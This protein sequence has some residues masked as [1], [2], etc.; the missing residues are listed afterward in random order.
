MKKYFFY[1]INLIRFILNIPLII[2][3]KIGN[4]YA[5]ILKLIDYRN[6]SNFWQEILN[7]SIYEFKSNKIRIS[8]NPS[9]FIQFYTPSKIA[10]YRSKTFF[11]KEPE[12]IDWLNRCGDEKKYFF[13]IGS[14]MGIYSIYYAK[15]F[16][17]QVFSFE[18][19]YKN[20]EI[21]TKNIMLNSL[22]NNIKIISNPLSDD[23][24]FSSFIQNDF[25]AG[26]AKASFLTNT[27][28]KETYFKNFK[29][30]TNEVSYNTLGLSIDNLLDLK[31]I[32]K[33]DLIKIDVDGNELQIIEG[34][35][36]TL[37]NLSGISMLIEV[38]KETKNEINDLMLKMGFRKTLSERDNEIWEKQ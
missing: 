34:L 23:F 28:D 33:P 19:S 32:P 13:D 15:K 5:K 8:K 25:S 1:F 21:L 2:I 18:P 10:G 36:K 9:K 17:A 4:N 6:H 24:K 20:L 27:Q 31:L 26:E 3:I 7:K 30:K 11:S 37:S 29:D 14:N 16:N 38:R 35:K 22:Q 12:T